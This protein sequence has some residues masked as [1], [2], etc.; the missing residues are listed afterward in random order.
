MI[1]DDLIQ[2]QE[3]S[4][5]P[6][7]DSIDSILCFVKRIKLLKRKRLYQYWYVSFKERTRAAS[8]LGKFSGFRMLRLT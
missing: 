2:T 1:T 8:V 5:A 7:Q 6:E 3:G 4:K